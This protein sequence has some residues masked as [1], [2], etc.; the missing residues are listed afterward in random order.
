MCLRIGLLFAVVG[1]GLPALSGAARAEA[2]P[3]QVPA[4]PAAVSVVDGTLKIYIVA[5]NKTGIPV[6]S[7]LWC[8][9]T[10]FLAEGATRDYDYRRYFVRA[11]V[12]STLV[13]C[14]VKLPYR[15]ATTDPATAVMQVD[16][17][18]SAT[19]M[20]GSVIPFVPAPAKTAFRATLPPITFPLPA[21]GATTFKPV[22][23]FI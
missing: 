9:A 23:S 11:T 14:T 3:P 21:A 19:P 7:T 18:I 17:A 4:A 2:S 6:S 12:T 1:A 5:V 13:S 22:Y 8:S 10:A 20:P 16:T 15:A